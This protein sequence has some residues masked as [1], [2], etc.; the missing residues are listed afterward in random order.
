MPPVARARTHL[1]LAVHRIEGQVLERELFADLKAPHVQ[2]QVHPLSRRQEDLPHGARP[3]QEV[4]IRGY[5]PIGE[6][7]AAADVLDGEPVEASVGAVEQPE[8][9]KPRAYLEAGG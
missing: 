3:I 7:L 5:Y 6:E 9:V 2:D 1:V 4:A 8:A